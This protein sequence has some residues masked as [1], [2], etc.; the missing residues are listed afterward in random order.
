MPACTRL[1]ATLSSPRSASLVPLP[2]SLDFFVFPAL[3]LGRLGQPG[4]GGL[5]GA[6]GRQARAIYQSL[7][8]PSIFPTKKARVTQAYFHDSKEAQNQLAANNYHDHNRQVICR[9]WRDSGCHRASDPGLTSRA[10]F[11]LSSLVEIPKPE[12]RHAP[13]ALWPPR[14]SRT[15]TAAEYLPKGAEI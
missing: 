4:E 2:R 11:W 14:T 8:F 5:P 1:S 12:A 7:K 13:A 10:G 9:P 15:S 3:F 6:D